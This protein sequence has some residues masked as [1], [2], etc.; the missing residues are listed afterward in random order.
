M[1]ESVAAIRLPFQV[2]TDIQQKC[3]LGWRESSAL[4]VYVDMKAIVENYAIVND[5]QA[6]E[7]L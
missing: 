4:I 2:Q 7:V 5:G 3:N 1:V 6:F